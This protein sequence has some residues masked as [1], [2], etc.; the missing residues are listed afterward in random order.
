LIPI[1]PQQFI[2][3]AERVAQSAQ[4]GDNAAVLRNGRRAFEL[5]PNDPDVQAPL[6]LLM[7]MAARN[8]GNAARAGDNASIA[9][10]LD[11]SLDS[12]LKQSA[13]KNASRGYPTPTINSAVSV[14]DILVDIQR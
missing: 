4:E 1:D 9:S 3:V 7:S 14:S 5:A 13:R 8:S 2:Q 6:Y 11:P 10:R 12:R